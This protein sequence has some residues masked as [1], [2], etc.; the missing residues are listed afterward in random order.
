MCLLICLP[1]SQR[2]S[3]RCI[4]YNLRVWY[5][6]KSC[7]MTCMSVKSV[8]LQ[9]LLHQFVLESIFFLLKRLCECKHSTKKKSTKHEYQP[10]P[11]ETLC[12]PWVTDE[13]FAVVSC[14]LPG[15]WSLPDQQLSKGLAIQCH[16]SQQ[17]EKTFLNPLLQ[18]GLWGKP[19]G[20]CW[21]SAARRQE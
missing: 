7:N 19:L 9:F 12:S 8:R 2:E 11:A 10:S 18:F 3:K 20:W 14:A 6:N 16:R 4:K 21:S 5:R 17:L 1:C 15:L 13:I